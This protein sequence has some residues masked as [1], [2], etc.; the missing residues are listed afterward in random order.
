MLIGVEITRWFLI[1]Q[2]GNII[3]MN[4][5]GTFTLHLST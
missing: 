1:K 2:G 5:T 4:P 3:D